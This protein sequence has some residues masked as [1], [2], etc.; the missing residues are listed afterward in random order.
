ARQHQ[1][2][3]HER[4]ARQVDR[5]QTETV[6]ELLALEPRKLVRPRL[7]VGR[8]LRDDDGLGHAASPASASVAASAPAGRYVITTR[9]SARKTSA[10]TARISSA[11][12]DR[13]GGRM[14]LIISGLPKS[15]AYID[16][17][18]AF[19]LV[20]CSAPSS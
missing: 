9:L 8:P 13:Y 1:R 5:D 4:A 7:A 19:S 12:V 2:G 16:S 6:R 10:Q 17:R 14:S 18:S 20:P 15:V 11:V 3:G